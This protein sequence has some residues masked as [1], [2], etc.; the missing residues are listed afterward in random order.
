MGSS[1]WKPPES[2]YEQ[3]REK[4]RTAVKIKDKTPCKLCLRRLK[5]EQQK[6]QV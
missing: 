3:H 1:K 6:S 4:I 5:N 2:E